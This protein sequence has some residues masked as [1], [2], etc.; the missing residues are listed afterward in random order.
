MPND[1]VN[2]RNIHTLHA[3]LVKQRE[4]IAEQ[5][6]KIATLEGIL[7]PMQVELQQLK[8]QVIVLQAMTRGGG[9]TSG[10]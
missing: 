10:N 6:A 8:Q 5:Q 9:A 2:T 3:G 7:V 4:Q 1:D